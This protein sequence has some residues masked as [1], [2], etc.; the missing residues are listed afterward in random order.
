MADCVGLYRRGGIGI[1]RLPCFGADRSVFVQSAGI[2]KGGNGVLEIFAEVAIDFTGGETGAI[3]QNLS[4]HDG[5]TFRI[6]ANWICYF[7]VVYQGWVG[8]GHNGR[9]PRRNRLA[10]MRTWLNGRT[11][12]G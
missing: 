2:L 11:H 7:G 10:V 4:P 5:G 6:E 8:I 12:G 3:E 1:E 9:T